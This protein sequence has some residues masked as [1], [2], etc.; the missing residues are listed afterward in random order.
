MI[1]FFFYIGTESDVVDAYTDQMYMFLHRSS[2]R[3]RQHLNATIKRLRQGFD[4][5]IQSYFIR[6]IWRGGVHYI[7]GIVLYN[8]R[9]N[10]TYRRRYSTHL[11]VPAGTGR[12][13]GKFLALSSAPLTLRIS[14]LN[15]AMASS[16]PMPLR[17]VV[18]AARPPT[19][20]LPLRE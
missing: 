13:D 15:V 16:S 12:D 19:T 5:N 9:V 7:C 18:P 14:A 17:P 6:Y 3:D 8:G 11:A 2:R 10:Y 1:F 20:V 4:G